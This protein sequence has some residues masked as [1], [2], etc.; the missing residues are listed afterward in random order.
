M[1]CHEMP[2]G[3]ACF[4][5]LVHVH[6]HVHAHA[7]TRPRRALPCCNAPARPL[8]TLPY[9]GGVPAS[10]H[11]GRALSTL[12]ISCLSSLAAT[13][14]ASPHLV[15]P[16]PTSPGL[17]PLRL[18]TKAHKGRDNIRL[19]FPSACLLASSH[20]DPIFRTPLEECRKDTPFIVDLHLLVS[21]P[22]SR[23]RKPTDTLR[24]HLLATGCRRRRA[25]WLYTVHSLLEAFSPSSPTDGTIATPTLPQLHTGLTLPRR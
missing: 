1:R 25:V 4:L 18:G 21:D 6:V 9:L 3:R 8:H 22:V 15:S 10:I 14:I 13:V 23:Q 11:L 5:T 7:H 24:C 12:R 2:H 16:H 20:L 17:S 19:F